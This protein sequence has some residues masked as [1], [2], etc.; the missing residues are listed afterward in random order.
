[1]HDVGVQNYVGKY[2][3]DCFP[4]NQNKSLYKSASDEDSKTDGNNGSWPSTGTLIIT[5]GIIFAI[6]FAIYRRSKKSIPKNNNYFALEPRNTSADE[7]SILHRGLLAE[8]EEDTAPLDDNVLRS[9]TSRYKDNE[10]LNGNVEVLDTNDNDNQSITSFVDTP[11]T[12]PEEQQQQ[13]RQNIFSISRHMNL[14][15]ML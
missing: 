13:Q 8:E 1:M 4:T 2:S 14:L 15:R 3:Q 6:V 5:I 11:V 10:N 7:D 9:N 12:F